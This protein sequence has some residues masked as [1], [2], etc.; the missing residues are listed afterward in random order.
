MSNFI[1]AG[2]WLKEGK[3]VRRKYYL[4][5]KFRIFMK[6]AL[7]FNSTRKDKEGLSHIFESKDFSATDWEIF[8]E[9]NKSLSDEEFESAYYCKENV[10]ESIMK[11]FVWVTT[12]HAPNLSSDTVAQKFKEI[13][14]D[15][16]I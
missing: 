1:Q 12:E 4:N 13:F 3:S 16:L 11:A 15:K 6:G 10:K 9:D 5:P 14:G 7:F 2:E 8:E